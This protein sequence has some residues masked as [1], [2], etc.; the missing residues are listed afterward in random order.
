LDDLSEKYFD[1]K[2]M[3]YKEITNNAKINFKDV[4]L[5]IASDYS[6]EDVYITKL[7]YDKQV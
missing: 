1:Y 3:S 6:V 2:M 5:A 7:L 4:D